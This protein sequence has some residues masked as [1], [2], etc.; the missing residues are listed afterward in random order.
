VLSVAGVAG[1]SYGR[2][3]G[4][5][6]R[7][8]PSRQTGDSRLAWSCHGYY[9]RRKRRTLDPGFQSSTNSLGLT[10]LAVGKGTP[11]SAFLAVRQRDRCGPPR[12]HHGRGRYGSQQFDQGRA[13]FEYTIGKSQH[14]PV[15]AVVG[16]RCR[17]PPNQIV[18]LGPG[19][20]CRQDHCC[21]R[22]SRCSSTAMNYD[23]PQAG[24]S[25]PERDQFGDVFRS[26]RD[27]TT[28]W[29]MNVVESKPQGLNR[30]E[31]RP[32]KS[33]AVSKNRDGVCDARGR[34]CPTQELVR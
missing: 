33:I 34:G 4:Q 32:V 6:Q 20:N 24:P 26:G 9:V 17:Y 15:R 27:P 31:V 11:D 23:G 13:P 1:S 3:S 22:A 28:C 7:K 10:D 12:I 30:S 14:A 5:T 25:L 21:C 16:F 2:L 29:R 19:E 8:P 18:R